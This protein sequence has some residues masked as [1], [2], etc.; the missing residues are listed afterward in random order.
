MYNLQQELHK[1]LLPHATVL[2]ALI[3]AFSFF[4]L[5]SFRSVTR[6]TT[7]LG[8]KI[9]SCVENCLTLD[10]ITLLQM[11]INFYYFVI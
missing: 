6:T 1:P 10:L 5:Q 4:P 2:L 3:D 9:M 7:R 11:F 8:K